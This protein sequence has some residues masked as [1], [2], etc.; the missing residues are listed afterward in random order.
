M[1]AFDVYECK[2]TGQMVLQV[3]RVVLHFTVNIISH[4]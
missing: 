2:A 1:Y 3:I 4:L